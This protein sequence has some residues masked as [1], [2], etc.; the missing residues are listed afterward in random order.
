MHAE[1]TTHSQPL[2]GG[3]ARALRE[4]QW[5]TVVWN[6]AVNTT[7]YVTGV[8]QRYFGYSFQRSHNLMMQVHTAGHAVVSR[9]LKERME[10]DVYAMHSFGLKATIEP[11]A[12]GM[13]A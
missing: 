1:P 8:F 9:G 6:D 13:R 10:A 11:A 3:A 4:N 12:G 2:T 7:D 5:Q